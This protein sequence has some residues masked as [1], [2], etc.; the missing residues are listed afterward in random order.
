MLPGLWFRGML[1]QSLR[2]IR[3]SVTT[4][5]IIISLSSGEQGGTLGMIDRSIMTEGLTAHELVISSYH[6]D[7]RFAE[8][9]GGNR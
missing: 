9:S 7:S 8:Y 2:H 4:V 1:V 3:P 5:I 6:V